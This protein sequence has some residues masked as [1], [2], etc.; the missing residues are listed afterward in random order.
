MILFID[1]YDSFV[2]NL[3]QYIGE[4]NADIKV[5]RNDAVSV[6]EVAAMAPDRIVVSPGPGHPSEAGISIEVIRRFHKTIPILGICL[7]HQ[8]IGHCFGATVD[9]AETLLHGK[10]SR[11]YHNGKGILRGLPNPFVATRYHSL[12]VKEETL[13]AELESTAYTSDGEVMGLRHV[14]SPLF[15]LQFH[16]ESI[17][18]TEGK[19]IIS[20]FMNWK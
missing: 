14:D 1:N 19:L 7:G 17:L 13:P 20:N 12:A 15:G 2:Y 16:P 9:S 6:E 11:I 4:L 3:V 5:V 8:A 10:T 18:T